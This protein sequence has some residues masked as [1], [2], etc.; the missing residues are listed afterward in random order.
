MKTLKRSFTMKVV[1][2][3]LLF[4][5]GGAILLS[6]CNFNKY[7][8]VY[9]N[10]T[11]S[12][13]ET[14]YLHAKYLKYIERLA[15]Y[16][17]Y[18]ERG[19]KVDSNQVYEDSYIDSIISMED[20]IDERNSSNSSLSESSLDSV[21]SDYTDQDTF[22]FYN[23]KLNIQDTNF[24]YYVQNLKTGKVYSSPSLEK[25]INNKAKLTSFLKNIGDNN[26]YLVLNTKTSRYVTNLDSKKGYLST[27]NIS[28]VIK[29]MTGSL[30]TISP[31]KNSSGA[32]STITTTDNEYL[33]YTCLYDNM[34]YHDEFNEH[35][36]IF[37][38]LYNNYVHSFYIIPI[39][40]L[41]FAILFV[42]SIYQSGHRKKNTGINLLSIDK[43]YVDWL[44][45]STFCVASI[46][47]SYFYMPFIDRVSDKVHTRIDVIPLFKYLF[48]Y[49]IIF[50]LVYSCIRRI[51][52]KTLFKSTF[53]YKIYRKTSTAIHLFFENKNLTY[54]AIFYLLIFI[55]VKFIAT[56]FL[57]DGSSF[58]TMM[59]YIISAIAYIYVANI[60]IK[61]AAQLNVLITETKKITEGNLTHKIPED[62]LD[63]S[64]RKLGTYINSI[65][66][67]LSA[68][69]DEKLKS[70]RLKTELITNVSHDIK[71][72]LTSIINF[73]DL[74]KKEKIESE[75]AKSYLEILETKSWRLKTLIE[76]LVE[77]S[78]ASSGTINMNLER[79]NIV[80][81]IRQSVGEFEDRF[82]ERN[83][84]MVIQISEEPI[85]ILA[86]GRSTFRIIENIF[87]NVNKYALNGTRVYIDVIKNEGKVNVSVKNISANQLNIDSNELMERFVRGDISRNT[88]GSGLGLS[89]SKSLAALQNATFDIILDG[90]LFKAVVVFTT[91]E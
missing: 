52:N 74:L 26:A 14:D 86:D 42:I 37:Q 48:W 83:L 29:C 78:K 13:Y 90:D 71:T 79:L 4:I 66:D 82:K 61:L 84:D 60:L 58:G 41:L 47:Y 62:E 45:V 30:G 43:I 57:F 1:I 87:S 22:E 35:Y 10:G 33:V 40:L 51:K 77:A 24:V 27:D 69:V 63:H 20:S 11:N 44:F 49:P 9:P 54:R 19:Y 36:L 15:E 89:I 70:E 64:M 17:Q 67:G 32:S 18:T 38:S 23:Y 55:L 5:A 76:D 31:P 6:T 91:I 53:S 73:V 65:G 46:F 25:I 56:L 12:F 85:Y 2:Q 80:E 39:S 21:E 3:C 59:Y 68:A 34:P 28:W 16:I 88:E 8:S 7:I 81:L 50:L 75:N 72:P